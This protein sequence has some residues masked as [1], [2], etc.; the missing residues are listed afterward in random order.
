MKT[1]LVVG[2]L[3]VANVLWFNMLAVLRRRGYPVSYMNFLSDL[4]AYHL[5][6]VNTKPHHD[7]HKYTFALILLYL[8]VA[9]VVVTIVV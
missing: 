4:K 9:A 6:I 1:A 2:L 5:L 7:R 8:V 3:I